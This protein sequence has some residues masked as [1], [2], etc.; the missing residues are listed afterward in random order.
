MLTLT[1]FKATLKAAEPPNG[2]P[3]PLVA[4]WNDAKG[5]WDG[6]HRVAQDIE[7]NDGAWIHAYLHRKEGDASNAA[8]W[9]HRA[10]KPVARG[11]LE[12]EWEAIAT[13][14]L[15]EA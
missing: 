4:L 13:A 15:K 7:S 14:L 11:S 9:Y 3:A 1:D 6:A 8:Y 10:G 12:E 2:L 5:D